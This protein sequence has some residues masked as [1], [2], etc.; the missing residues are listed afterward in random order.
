M[1]LEGIADATRLTMPILSTSYL[2][3]PWQR[4]FDDERIRRALAHGL[5]RAPIVEPTGS[6]A[7]YGGF[8]P[9]AMPGHSHDLAPAHD[10]ER[11]R[12]LLSAAGYPDGRGLPE[13][14]LLHFDPGLSETQ[15]AEIAGK[16]ETQWQELGVRLRQ[17]WIPFDDANAEIAKG[18][19]FWEWGWVSDYPDPDGMLGTFIASQQIP[20]DDE[21]M[22]IL[23]EARSHRSRDERLGLYRKADELLVAEQVRVIP[24]TY[25]IWHVLH[26]PWLE[27]IWTHPLGI[28]TFDDVVVAK[29]RLTR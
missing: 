8:L 17:E 23:S 11:A 2:G 15:R 6:P 12:A 28:G 18:T 22:T 10:L 9:P 14:R 4:P 20:F 19:A 13:L 1:R 29:E 24:T 5:D 25:D 7:A 26:R 16:W 21:L 27:G 3:F